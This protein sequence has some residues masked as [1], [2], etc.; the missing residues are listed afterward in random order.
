MMNNMSK[1]SKK[2][3]LQDAFKARYGKDH[4]TILLDLDSDVQ[5]VL[6][7]KGY[8]IAI[9]SKKKNALDS[10]ED[11]GSDRAAFFQALKEY[12]K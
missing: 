11:F 4:F 10:M 1:D 2:S 3:H 8:A 5:T 7:N 12:M 6:G 9:I